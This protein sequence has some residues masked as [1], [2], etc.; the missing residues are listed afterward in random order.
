MPELN[1]ESPH[2]GSPQLLS[3]L[4]LPL[5]LSDHYLS[6][7]AKQLQEHKGTH[8]VTLNAEMCMQAEQNPALASIIHA[9][10]L[11]VPD[12]AGIIFYLWLQGRKT[13]RCPGI[14]LAEALLRYVGTAS[15]PE[16]LSVPA[17]KGSRS[18]LPYSVFFYGG[19][20][21]VNQQASAVWQ[22]KLPELA[23]AGTQHGYLSP[24]EQQQLCATL[25][26][27]QPNIIFVGMGVPRQELWIAAHRHLCPHAIWIVV[28]GSFDIWSGTKSRAPQWL[29]N[30]NLEW[31]YRLYQ[32]PWRWRRMLALPQFAW[33]SLVYSFKTRVRA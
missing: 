5:H 13:Q 12:G 17:V 11:V 19:T 33:R 8:V 26:S 10:E 31:V 4:G 7:L 32:E 3:V 27:L 2:V 24:E 6:W 30:N 23:I 16:W 18:S 20:P 28:G 25:K 22:R 15:S 29:R 21:E 1:Q 9:A 14:E